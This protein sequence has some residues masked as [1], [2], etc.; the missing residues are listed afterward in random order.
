[1]C[2]WKHIGIKSI[3]GQTEPASEPFLPIVSNAAQSGLSTMQVQCVNVP[4]KMVSNLR[5]FTH[6][7]AQI[8][9]TNPMRASG[10]EHNR[11]TRRQMASH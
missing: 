6:H 11:L 3:T 4:K 8:L 5:M 1:M 7:A 10:K 2:H 9:D